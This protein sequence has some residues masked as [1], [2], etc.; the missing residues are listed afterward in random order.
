MHFFLNFHFANISSLRDFQNLCDI[1]STNITYLKAGSKST[2]FLDFPDLLVKTPA[3]VKTNLPR[4]LVKS[5]AKAWVF[6]L[7]NLDS[8]GTKKNEQQKKCSLFGLHFF[9]KAIK[10]LISR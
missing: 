10:I 2:P 9:R 5:P 4:L 3:K 8:L 6:I 1:F 7:L